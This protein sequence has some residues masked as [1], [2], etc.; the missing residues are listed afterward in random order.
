MELVNTEVIG[1]DWFNVSGR[2]TSSARVHIT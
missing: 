1:R 2:P